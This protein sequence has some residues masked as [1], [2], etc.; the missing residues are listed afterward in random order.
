[1][2]NSLP[3][4]PVEPTVSE[5]HTL[6]FVGDN[7]RLAA[8]MDYPTSPAPEGGYPLLFVVPNATN[9]TRDGFLHLMRMGTEQGLAVFRWDKR[10]TGN[11]GAGAGSATTDTLKAFE[12][13]LKQPNIAPNRV[14]I[15][16]QNEGTSILGK[17]WQKFIAIQRPLGVILLGNMLDEQEV[18]GIDTPLH[19]VMSKNDW[20]AW[21]TYAENA[22]RSHQRKH[23]YKASFY[24][25]PN[26]NRHLMYVNGGSFHRGAHD[27][28][29]EWIKT[30]C[31][32]SPLT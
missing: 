8:Q 1:M 23:G 6:Y 5:T 13:A 26:T 11:S 28:M 29:K 30:I 15:V 31:G 2:T 25:A 27:S 32:I 18:I 22:S 9:T 17:A 16:A 12:T 7:V 3:V 21:Q 10:G 24:V 14:V 20:N 19:I 4:E